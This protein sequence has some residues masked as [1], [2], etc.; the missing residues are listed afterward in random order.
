[1]LE[2]KIENRFWFQKIK[3]NNLS[4]IF[5]RYKNYYLTQNFKK[6]FPTIEVGDFIIKLAEKRSEIKHAQSLRYSVFYKERFPRKNSE[7]KL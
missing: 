1:M 4:L 5:R 7:W 6:P 2:K 3:K